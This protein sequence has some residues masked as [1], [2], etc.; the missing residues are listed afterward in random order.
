MAHDCQFSNFLHRP[1]SLLFSR[2]K[3]KC[4]KITP[5][6]GG[7]IRCCFYCVRSDIAVQDGGVCCRY[8]LCLAVY[9]TL[10][11]DLQQ[12]VRNGLKRM[13]M[14]DYLERDYHQYKW[15]LRTLDCRLRYFDI[16]YSDVAVSVDD[17]FIFNFYLQLFY[18]Q[19]FMYIYNQTIFYVHVY[20]NQEQLFF[21]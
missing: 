20:N 3:A 16:K 6:M 15:S 4:L 1:Q 12:H 13:E 7:Q 21:K 8:L 2:F 9:E 5:F 18:L 11:T 10:K 17:V 19:F 14:L